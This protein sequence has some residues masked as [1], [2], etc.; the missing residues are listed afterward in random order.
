MVKRT[1][2]M[3]SLRSASPPPL[4]EAIHT[5][6][7]PSQ[8]PENANAIK[9]DIEEHSP[10]PSRRAK[11]QPLADAFDTPSCKIYGSRG[12]VPAAPAPADVLATG[13]ESADAV[14]EEEEQ[15]VESL[16]KEHGERVKTLQQRISEQD[17][18]LDNFVTAVAALPPPPQASTRTTNEHDPT[19]AALM[20]YIGSDH[21]WLNTPRPRL[22]ASDAVNVPWM[23][24]LSEQE[25]KDWLKH[26]STTEITINPVTGERGLALDPESSGEE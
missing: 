11:T 10:P 14:A 20:S 23:Q 12:D 5:P 6:S 4:S 19:L 3:T 16:A 2:F 24:N 9:S 26:A 18:I 15:Q 22:T 13:T 8:T 1:S 25:R 17:R 7:H 21:Y